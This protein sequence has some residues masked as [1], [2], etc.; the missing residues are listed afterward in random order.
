MTNMTKDI[1][2]YE[3]IYSIS[4]NAEIVNLKTGKVI[5]PWIVN[6]SYRKVRLYK[7]NQHK[8]FYLHRLVALNFIPNNENKPC[9]NHIDSNPANNNVENL[10]WCTH[11]ENMTHARVNNRFSY[12]G[13]Y[14]RHKKSGIIYKSIKQ[15]AD[16]LGIKQNTLVYRIKRNSKCNEFEV[17]RKR[18]V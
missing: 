16:D 18:D 8:D 6:I 17:M 10:E 11:H 4:Q 9:V 13:V 12:I 1:N 14:V 7:D 15:A 3:G 5:K 2:G